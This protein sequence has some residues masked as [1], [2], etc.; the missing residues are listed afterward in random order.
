[1]SS[2][3]YLTLP[4]APAAAGKLPG[5]RNGWNQLRARG[6]N[7]LPSPGGLRA[8]SAASF[9]AFIPTGMRAPHSLRP[10]LLAPPG[11][12]RGLD[13]VLLFVSVEDSVEIAIDAEA[14][15]AAR[16]NTGERE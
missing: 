8:P 16:R 5:S 13:H 11:S 12:V 7:P 1:M 2:R 4:A 14:L 6:Q 10:G 9:V 3:Q 15:A